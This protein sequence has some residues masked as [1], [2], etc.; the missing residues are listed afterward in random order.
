LHLGE[1]QSK[2][3]DYLKPNT[4]NHKNDTEVSNELK[5]LKRELVTKNAIQELLSHKCVQEWFKAVK[6]PVSEKTVDNYCRGMVRYLRF[7]NLWCKPETLLVIRN[8]ENGDILSAKMLNSYVAEIRIPASVRKQDSASIKSFFACHY[9]DLPKKSGRITVAPVKE[10][11]KPTIEQ[12]VRMTQGQNYRDRAMIWFKYSAPVRKTTLIYLQ[13]KDLKETNDDALPIMV[14]VKPNKMKGQYASQY[15]FLH[16]TAYEALTDYL[17]WRRRAGETIRVEGRT[18]RIGEKLTQDSFVFRSHRQLNGTRAKQRKAKGIPLEQ[19]DDSMVEQ[20]FKNACEGKGFVFSP[21]DSRDFV[22][23]GMRK[24]KVDKDWREIILGHKVSATAYTAVQSGEL[25]EAF[26]DALPYIS[27]KP[28]ITPKIKPETTLSEV[29]KLKRQLEEMYLT[30]IEL[31]KSD[32]ASYE[33]MIRI[34]TDPTIKKTNEIALKMA[35]R[36]L[37]KL[38]RL[39]GITKQ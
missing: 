15:A 21:D 34:D 38:H 32:I 29:Q 17:E 6:Q 7:H 37:Q 35:K 13:F 11:R 31:V 16:R 12:L 18:K 8:R 24:A 3:N 23:D 2:K 14:H 10:K 27:P 36:Q 28:D 22:N 39:L 20:I 33:E 30:E 26:K 5:P 19:L 4:E 1:R 9:K 25:L